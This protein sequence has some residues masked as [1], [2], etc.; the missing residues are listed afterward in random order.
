MPSKY[1]ITSYHCH[2]LLADQIHRLGNLTIRPYS[3]YT[4]RHVLY[5]ISPQSDHCEQCLRHNQYCELTLPSTSKVTRFHEKDR[6]LF[7]RTLAAEIKVFR[8]RR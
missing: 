7:E 8:L 2:R 5:V 3:F 1:K 4:N 6:R